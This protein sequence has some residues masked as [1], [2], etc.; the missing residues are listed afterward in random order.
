[1]QTRRRSADDNKVHPKRPEKGGRRCGYPK[2]RIEA[3]DSPTPRSEA[4]TSRIDWAF[5]ETTAERGTKTKPEENAGNEMGSKG[6]PRPIQKQGA[7][8]A[9]KAK[10]IPRPINAVSCRRRQV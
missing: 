1:M 2:Q 9:M 10:G 3:I 7:K 4:E 6:R 8:S 5:T